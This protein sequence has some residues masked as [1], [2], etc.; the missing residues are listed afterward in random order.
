MKKYRYTIQ[1]NFLDG[2]VD[3]RRIESP[4]HPGEIIEYIQL[5]SQDKNIGTGMIESVSVGEDFEVIEV[6]ENILTKRDGWIGDTN[7]SGG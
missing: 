1:I 4:L 2:D 6:D 7:G 5:L 3:I